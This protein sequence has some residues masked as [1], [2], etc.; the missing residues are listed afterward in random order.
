MP[1]ITPNPDSTATCIACGLEDP[2]SKVQVGPLS[3]SLCSWCAQNLGQELIKVTPPDQTTNNP[4]ER[5][6]YRTR[7][8]K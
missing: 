7:R 3:F 6:Y 5:I 1:V 4:V 8:I 2:S